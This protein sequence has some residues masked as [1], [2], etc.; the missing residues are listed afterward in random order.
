M[1][2]IWRAV[3][4]FAPPMLKIPNLSAGLTALRVKYPETTHPPSLPLSLPLPPPRPRRHLRRTFV[5]YFAYRA[6]LSAIASSRRW[7]SGEA[8]RHLCRDGQSA[9]TFARP[10]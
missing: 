7:K 8:G 3:C 4:E 1:M 2:P 9:R 5:V 10:P 6:D